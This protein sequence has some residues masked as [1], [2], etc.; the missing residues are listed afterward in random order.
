MNN[1]PQAMLSWRNLIN[2]L[3]NGYGYSAFFHLGHI[4]LQGYLSRSNDVCNYSLIFSSWIINMIHL[5]EF[6]RYC[7]YH[8]PLYFSILLC[9]NK[10][11]FSQS[12]L[13]I[14]IFRNETRRGR[15]GVIQKQ[16]YFLV[17]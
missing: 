7:F 13:H 12:F 17:I 10:F 2:I 8:R 9:S 6:A 15:H 4:G 5:L 3:I 11:L 14:F 16:Y 1:W